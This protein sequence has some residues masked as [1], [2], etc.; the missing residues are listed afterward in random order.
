MTSQGEYIQVKQAF[1][2]A[3]P[4]VGC[5]NTC[6][7]N[8]TSNT[9]DNVIGSTI[10]GLGTF[11]YISTAGGGLSP[12]NLASTVA[13]LG[14]SGYLSSYSNAVFQQGLT[15]SLVGLGSIGYLSSINS[16]IASSIAG[17][18]SSG[19]LSSIT[20]LPSTVAGLGSSGYLSS[21][22]GLPSTVEGLGTSGYLSSYS[23]A[24]FQGGLTSSLEG[25][26][27]IGYL[28]TAGGGLSPLNLASTVA[29]LGS[30]GYLS[31]YSNAVFQQG[32]TSSLVGLGSIG[33]LSSI[34]LTS[35]IAGLGS[36]GYLSSITGLPS[37]V[38]GL[39]SSGYLSS[40]SNAVFQQGLTSSLVG[41]GSIGYLSSID[42]TSTVA[43]LG[44]SGY[45]SS[46]SNAVFQEGLTSSLVGLGSI[47]YLSSIDLTSTVAGLGS[48]GYLSSY[49]NAVFQQ[50]LT[51]SLQGLGTL[52]YLSSL[53]NTIPST[54]AGLGT[55]GYVSSL[56]LASTTFVL[57][58]AISTIAASQG[59]SSLSTVISQG[60]STMSTNFGQTFSSILS[61]YT[62]FARL[63]N[64]LT[65]DQ[66][67][68][69]DAT[70]SPSGL[71]YKTVNAAI[72]NVLTGDTVWILPGT[73]NLTSPITLPAGI[74][75]RGLSVQT[76]IIQMLNV[77]A[78]TILITMGENTRVEDLTLKLTSQ[79]HHNLTGIE[80]AGTTT[81]TGKIRT[82]VLTVDNSNAP[83]N[84]GTSEVT[85]ILASGTGTLGTASFSFNSLKGSTVNIYS[86]GAGKKRGV[87]VTGQNV[88]STRDLNIYVAAPQ[89]IASTG[90]YIGVETNNTD[91]I[92]SIQLRTTTVGTVSTILGGA[93]T[94]SDILQTTPAII[95]DPTYLASAGIQIGPGTDLVTKTAG[96]HG[97][98]VYNYPTTIYYGLK[99]DIKSGISGGYLW[100]GTQA[101]SA[102]VFPD[103]GTNPAYYRIQ[104]PCL[105]TG[106]SVGLNSNSG[107]GNTTTI[108]VKYTPL[109]GTITNTDFTVTLNATDLFKNFYDSSIRLNTGDKLH[110]Q[111]TYTGNNANTAH[112][113]TVQVDT[114]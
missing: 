16:T 14:S 108:L 22:T 81:V 13:G 43:G 46:Y 61:S 32:L 65:V 37:T 34:D 75:V 28:S 86:N 12:L 66:I 100:P 35:S 17:L 56:S 50:G 104:Q 92:G 36:S 71:P 78:N 90:S 74:S 60:F 59:I 58:N 10:V 98:S 44:S 110:V 38:T 18:G 80:F 7:S 49:S 39:G 31:S 54:V 106:L 26:G 42:L 95:T 19:Y 15:S 52:G 23:N 72:N 40:Y 79:Q 94:S 62:T 84:S 8:A 2:V 5:E 68:G 3:Y 69:N 85:G 51:S 113:L 103:S 30:S 112:D 101:V 63:G 89:N 20:G 41:L 21:I 9:V 96:N 67:N 11:G 102:G 87:L 55:S 97:F 6:T 47:G 45:L 27:S 105:I 76:T 73:Y 93:Y 1:R 4:Y 70:A 111:L 77:T 57:Q 91:N 109:G 29:G 107:T 25:L 83:Y 24:V 48:S 82:C 114:F 88:M 53:N 33:Y 64:T 99:G